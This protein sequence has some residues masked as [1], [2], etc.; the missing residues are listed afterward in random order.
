MADRLARVEKKVDQ[1]AAIIGDM[2]SQSAAAEES[3][4]N[5]LGAVETFCDQAARQIERVSPNAIAAR[6][7]E[8]APSSNSRWLLWTIAGLLVILAIVIGLRMW[9]ARP[10]EP[11]IAKSTVPAPVPVPVPVAQ[12]APPPVEAARP[13]VMHVEID[14]T[15]PS[16]ISM[17][18]LD[19]THLAVT[20]I[21][22]GNPRV[23][24]LEHPALLRTGNA[25]GLKIRLNGKPL[26]PLGPRG[27]VREILFKNGAFKISAPEPPVVH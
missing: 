7:P 11:V 14:S 15:E 6:A 19:G 17:T 12:P 10:A 1:H 20:V 21:Q 22:P 3:F 5:L 23:I 24:D 2:R 16:W 18:G 4:R 25:G 9:P 27:K 13:G 26:G 8:P